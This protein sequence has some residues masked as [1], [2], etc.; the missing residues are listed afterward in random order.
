MYSVVVTNSKGAPE[1]EFADNMADVVRLT[2]G[3]KAAW[4]VVAGDGVVVRYEGG[5]I[6]GAMSGS[7]KN[8]LR[9]LAY[10]SHMSSHQYA[11]GITK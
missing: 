7:W 11:C 2:A 4:R 5:K 6:S 10:R 3:V 1:I 8:S 9:G